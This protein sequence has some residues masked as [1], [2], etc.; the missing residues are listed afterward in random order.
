M[1]DNPRLPLQTLPVFLKAAQTHN[2][3]A[4]ASAL[5]LTHSAVSQQIRVLE[6]RLGF[7]VFERRGRRIALNPAGEALS[8]GVEAALAQ[9][10]AATRSAAAL[11]G[12]STERLRLTALPSFAQRWLMPRMSRWRE[13]HPEITIEL[14]TSQ[15]VV[16]LQREGFHVALRQGLGGW[17]G[18]LDEPLIDS[19][20]VAVG[21][22]G[23]VA[24]LDGL[25]IEA[26][27]NEPLL[28][29][30]ELWDRW[31]AASGA[32]L[33]S[34]PVATFNDAALMLQAVEQGLGLAMVREVLAADALRAGRLAR[35]SSLTLEA[36]DATKYFVAYP[37]ALRDW[38]PL[39]ALRAWLRDEVAESIAATPA[40][41]ERQLSSA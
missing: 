6:T 19:P 23:T 27:A 38:P 30:A 8:R 22:P 17:P 15:Q 24:R 34:V 29:F 36:E 39:V 16:D 7:A 32:T 20:L 14:H 35:V 2:L 9:L 25:P 13:R 18:L 26:V 3:R 11:A 37:P 41:R 28:G 33:R 40:V 12:G 4:T 31:F 10:E 1:P 5:H 21:A